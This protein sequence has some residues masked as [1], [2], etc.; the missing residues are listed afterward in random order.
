MR[1]EVVRWLKSGKDDLK[2]A[3]DNFKIRNYD[4][5]SFLCQQTVEKLLKAVLIEK[6]RKFPK[7]HDLVRLGKL[8]QIDKNLLKDCEKLTFVYT[9]TRYPDAGIKK[10]TRGEVEEDIK[11][12]RRIIKWATKQLKKI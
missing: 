2:K 11:A 3:E 12:A 7:I 4:L 8:A 5:T 1:E 9:E 6:T 10:Y